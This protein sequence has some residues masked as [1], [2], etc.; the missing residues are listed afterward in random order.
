MTRPLSGKQILL[1]VSGGISAYKSVYLLRFLQK[2]G[3]DVRVVMTEAACEFVAPLTFET[4]SRHPVQV[5]MFGKPRIE[6]LNS[7]VEHVDLAAWAQLIIITPATANTLAKLA[8]GRADDLLSTVVCASPATVVLAPA[9]NDVMWNNPATQQNLALLAGRG[10]RTVAPES[11]E[12]ACGYEATGRMAEPETILEFVK[13]IFNSDFSGRRVLVSAGGTEEDLDPVRCLTNRSSG[14]MGFA[15]AAAARDR[16]ATVTIV[17]GRTSTPPPPGIELV[18]VRTVEEM[19]K[20]LG[21]RFERSDIL[22]MAAAVSDFRPTSVGTR[23]HKGGT[24][25]LELTRTEDV[26][27]ALGT[28]KGNRLIIG[29]ALE[30]DEIEANARTKMEKKN[31]DLMV[32]NNPIQTGAGFEVDTNDV[33]IIGPKGLQLSTGLRSKREIAETILQ[34]LSRTGAF[35]KLAR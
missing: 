25:T 29:F 20:A 32:V 33:T 2:E 21:E 6:E 10:Y 31:C 35:R 11:G 5:K 7:P 13:N 9:M 17:A 15:L 3:A 23:K 18:R 30:T 16:G 1:G 22:I 12:L 8:A 28:R 4:L 19:S 26:L 24:W 14:K 27:A 34:T